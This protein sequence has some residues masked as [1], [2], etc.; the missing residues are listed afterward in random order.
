MERVVELASSPLE[1]LLSCAPT[2]PATAWQYCLMCFCPAVCAGVPVERV[3]E[4]A[5]ALLDH[6]LSCAPAMRASA[7]QPA[8]KATGRALKPAAKVAQASKTTKGKKRK[9]AAA[10]VLPQDQV[11]LFAGAVLSLFIHVVVTP[12]AAKSTS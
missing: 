3:V 11:C 1:Y 9:D 5:S 2:M 4:L 8:P 12:D 6:L 10:E 7:A